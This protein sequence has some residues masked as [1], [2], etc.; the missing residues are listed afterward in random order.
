M[1]QG[2]GLIRT[3]TLKPRAHVEAAC[4]CCWQEETTRTDRAFVSCCLHEQNHTACWYGTRY[5]GASDNP[6]PQ[7]HRDALYEVAGTSHQERSNSVTNSL[8][9]AGALDA[10][11]AVT[12]VF[13]QA[14]QGS[15]KTSG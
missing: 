11:A 5:E 15:T 1:N 10:A 8:V 6:P 3:M 14:G 7:V 4:S 12:E 2:E 13:L 9:Q